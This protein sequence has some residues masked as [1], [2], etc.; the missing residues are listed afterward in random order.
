MSER[1]YPVSA[2]FAAQANINKE[3]YEEM[4]ARSID[5]PEGFWADQ[6]NKYVTWFKP[7]LHLMFWYL[8]LSN[9]Q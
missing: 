5:D 8:N 6:A 7:C 3:Q 1:T 4:Y 2:E 9:Q